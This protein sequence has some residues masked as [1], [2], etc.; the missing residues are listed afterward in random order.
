MLDAMAGVRMID[1][2]TCG[3]GLAENSALPARLAELT[4]SL[5]DNLEVHMKAL[6]MT[7]ES[8]KLEHEAYMKLAHQMRAIASE[9]GAAAEQ[10][11]GCRALPVG[12]H[13][14]RAISAPAVLEAF[15]HLVKVKRELVTWLQNGAERDQRMLVEMTALATA[16]TTHPG[17][18]RRAPAVGPHR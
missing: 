1:E 14:A 17:Y 12:R 16:A 2:R 13:D 8:A 4:A 3:E 7:D 9:L 18:G 10:M 5:A 11:V 15:E 6:D